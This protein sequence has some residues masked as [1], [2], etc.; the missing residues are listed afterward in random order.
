MHCA[1]LEPDEFVKRYVIW[2][3][4]RRAGNDYKQF[5]AVNE[6]KEVLTTLEYDQCLAARDSAYRHP[7]AGKL[8]SAR[9]TDDREVAVVW[10]DGMTGLLCKGRI[11]LLLPGVITDLKTTRVK[12]AD[13]RALTRVASNFGYH[14]SLAAYQGG[15]SDVTGEIPGVKLIFVEQT[16]PHDVRVLTMDNALIAGW[17]RWQ[18]L[19]KDVLECSTSGVWPGCSDKESELKVWDAEAERET[20]TLDGEKI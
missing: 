8:L 13:D 17:D 3:G 16:P 20:V 10:R 11:D 12:V 15:V 9:N 7:V 2:S 6:G 18:S 1:V 5:C 19:L 14:I 4:G